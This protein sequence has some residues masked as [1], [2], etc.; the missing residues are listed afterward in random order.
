MDS[1]YKPVTDGTS[2]LVLS[3]RDRARGALLGVVIGDAFGNPL[4]GA[5]ARGLRSRVQRRASAAG[6][7]RYTD[8]AAM[9]VALAESLRDNGTVIPEHVLRRLQAHYEPA[10]GFGRGM[11]LALTEF[12]RGLPWERVAYAAW[13]EGSRGNGGAVR[14]GA[15]ALRRWKT[16]S[17]MLS[18]ATL[19]TRTTHAHDEAIAAAQ[20]QAA[21]VSSILTKPTLLAAPSDLL[22]AVR[23]MLSPS[24]Q[25][26]CDAVGDALAG[27]LSCEEIARRFGTSTLAIESVPAAI[28][29]FL[30]SHASFEGAVVDA[31]AMGGDV[32]SICAIVGCLVGALHGEQGIPA[33]WLA[34]I[35]HERPELS[36]LRALA[37][38]LCELEPV[39]FPPA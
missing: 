20:L 4:E 2:A 1:S 17:A 8:D 23:N 33:P 18:A 22:A 19:A 12:E 31:A 32:D 14:V 13:P 37:D 34:A 7:W 16:S 39:D 26:L 3:A 10:R 38:A 6:P 15:V 27:G 30:R 35:A 24:A 28:A 21:L 9:F 36:E 25:T 5:P 29:S 11:K